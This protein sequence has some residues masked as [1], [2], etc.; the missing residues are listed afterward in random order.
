MSNFLGHAPL[1]KTRYDRKV[2]KIVNIDQ[3][4][5]IYQYNQRMGGV[6]LF[7]N[8]RITNRGKKWY[9]PLFTNVLDAAMVNAWKLHVQM[10]KL[11]KESPMSQLDFRVEVVEA[12]I[13]ATVIRTPPG[14]SFINSHELAV[15]LESR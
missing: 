9:W 5:L 15:R 6:D 11:K 14:K 13:T 3:P 1:H 8:Y 12:L 7:D 10:M 2:H 4:H